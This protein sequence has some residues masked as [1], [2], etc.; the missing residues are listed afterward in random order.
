MGMTKAKQNIRGIRYKCQVCD[1]FDFCQTCYPGVALAH[2]TSHTFM[3]IQ[4]PGD[5]DEKDTGEKHTSIE[6]SE[7]NDKLV[8]LRTKFGQ[9]LSTPKAQSFTVSFLP[10]R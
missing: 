4:K 5:L 3:A 1:D 7:E 2:P 9:I 10:T 6:I 8:Q